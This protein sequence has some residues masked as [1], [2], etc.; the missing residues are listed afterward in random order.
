LGRRTALFAPRKAANLDF[1]AR[2]PVPF[3]IFPSSYKDKEADKASATRTHSEV[4]ISLPHHHHHHAGRE[5]YLSSP[6][7]QQ[8]QLQRY[9]EDEV[10]V[11]REEERYRRP[12][13]RK[14]VRE[15]VVTEHR[16]RRPQNSYQETRVDVEQTRRFETPIDQIER[17]YRSRSTSPPAHRRSPSQ[18]GSSAGV[19]NIGSSTSLTLHRPHRH[20]D[21]H[22]HEPRRETTVVDET[23]VDYPARRRTLSQGPSRTREDEDIT[24]ID[25]PSQQLAVYRPQP[26]NIPDE[27]VEPASYPPKAT[28]P[29]Y[30]DVGK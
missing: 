5:G 17:A 3:S 20:H 16:H 12:G 28:M 11:T 6:G 25:A 9:S 13:I 26:S 4:S 15:E 8:Q 23:I 22:H 24:T 2:V 7:A 10:R 1:E 19:S 30:D 14:E 18:V 21:H 29:L 27:I